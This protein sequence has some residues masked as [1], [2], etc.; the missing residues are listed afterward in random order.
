MAVALEVGISNLLPEFFANA[1]VLFGTLEAARTV[2]AGALESIPDSLYHLLILI[3]PNRH[4][5]TSLLLINTLQYIMAQNEK[6]INSFSS[7]SYKFYSF[8]P[9][10]LAIAMVTSAQRRAAMASK[11]G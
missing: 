4:T 2:S 8:W 1:L 6:E 7:C 11:V 3:Q 10:F 5:L 9:S